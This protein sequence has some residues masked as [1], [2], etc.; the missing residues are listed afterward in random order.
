MAAIAIPMPVPF[1]LLLILLPKFPLSPFLFTYKYITKYGRL[2]S[3]Y[4]FHKNIE[5]KSLLHWRTVSYLV[6]YMSTCLQVTLVL[7]HYH[8]TT[9]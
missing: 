5:K 1:G 4:T 8:M 3:G 6:A 7:P 9:F 2:P